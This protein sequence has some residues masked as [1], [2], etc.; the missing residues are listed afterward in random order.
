MAFNHTISAILRGQWLIE[1]QWADSQLPMVLSFMK[2]EAVDFG[3]KESKADI[4]PQLFSKK[5]AHASV[6]SVRP[7]SDVRG[8]PGGSIAM[9]TLAGPMLKRGDMCSYGMADQAQLV[10]RLANAD[11]IDGILLNIDSP[12]GQADGT[13]MLSDAIKNA[14]KSKPV[15]AIIDDGMAA[16]AAM[17]IASA[18]N[19]IFVT[20]ATDQVGSI[21][22][23]TQV[24]DWN[25]YYKEALKLNVQDIYAPQS[26]DKNKD[27]KDAVN[28]D[29]S[30][31]EADLAVLADQFINTVATNRAGKIKGD[32]WKTGKM[33][34]AKDAIRIGLIDGIK[35]FDQV[36][37]RMTKLI[38]Y[39][40]PSQHKK[41][42]MAFTK[43]IAA[44]KAES[45][46]V[47]EGGFLLEETQL[48]NI[49][50]A[51]EAS[52]G[53]SA[54]LATANEALATANTSLES[55]TA[56]LATAKE[57]SQ[58]SETTISTQAAR[59]QELEAEVAELGKQESGTGTT[60][61]TNKDENAEEKKVP[62]YLSDNDPA[63][64]WADKHL[65]KKK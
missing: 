22:V 17:W 40:T 58:T 65:R 28:G 33:F 54:S 39:P 24:A 20:Q 62:A 38:N 3:A 56:E 53:L 47:V 31:I 49:E 9:I 27:Y 48:N 34:Y 15:V 21:G 52:D 14:S 12:G 61:I 1:K 30:G 13:A 59:I 26:T 43:T 41:S 63:N 60:V 2:G 25:S 8:L 37:S 45:F 11:N 57:A 29:I 18:A 46:A 32:S 64:A 50:A 23:Y 19:E 51:L 35:S 7:S 6:Y 42:N 5:V 36:V 55:V 4:N 44:A 10:N 16:S